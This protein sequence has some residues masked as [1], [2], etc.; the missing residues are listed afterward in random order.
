M[1]VN[2][3]RAYP[4]KNKPAKDKFVLIKKKIV[5]ILILGGAWRDPAEQDPRKFKAGGQPAETPP[6]VGN[7]ESGGKIRPGKMLRFV[8]NNYFFRC[9]KCA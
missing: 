4:N 2:K 1:L 9:F 3:T 6:A 7:A 5:I 8:K